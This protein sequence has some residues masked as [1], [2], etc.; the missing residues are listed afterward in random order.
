MFEHTKFC[1]YCGKPIL[2]KEEAPVLQPEKIKMKAVLEVPPILQPKPVTKPV[3][4]DDTPVFGG[5]IRVR[6]VRSEER[7]VG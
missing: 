4:V 2:H 5:P 1:A 6:P 7:R 3:E